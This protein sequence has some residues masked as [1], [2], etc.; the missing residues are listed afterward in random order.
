MTNIFL[1]ISAEQRLNDQKSENILLYHYL[2]KNKHKSPTQ[3]CNIK[4][5]EDDLNIFE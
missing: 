4:S 3:N 2:M 1:A 5:H